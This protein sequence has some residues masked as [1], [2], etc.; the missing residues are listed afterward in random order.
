MLVTNAEFQISKYL[1]DRNL[2]LVDVKLIIE[3]VEVITD[4]EHGV[5]LPDVG[6][7]Q[8]DQAGAGQRAEHPR[9][10][11]HPHQALLPPGPGV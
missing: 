2:V 9:P 6:A 7:D 4:P 5:E 8:G 1:H 3:S 11:P 10:V